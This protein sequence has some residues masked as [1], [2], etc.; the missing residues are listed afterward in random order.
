M[1]GNGNYTFPTGTKYEGEMK[2]G[3]FHGKGTLHFPNGSKYEA[4]WENGKSI[5]VPNLISHIVKNTV[6]SNDSDEDTAMISIKIYAT[7]TFYRDSTHL[8]MAC[9]SLKTGNTVMVMT[10]A[11]IRNRAAALN[12]QVPKLRLSS[13]K[14]LSLGRL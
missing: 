14:K 3:M 8:P 5:E 7:L 11:S 9:R 2:D 13:F 1:E 10:D 12:L 6:M 4:T